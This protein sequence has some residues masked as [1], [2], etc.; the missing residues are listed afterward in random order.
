[1]GTKNKPGKFDCYAAA[2]PDEPMFVLLGRDP[3]APFLV[4]EWAHQRAATR[5]MTEQNIAKVNEARE[6]ARA[7]RAWAAKHDVET[8]DE[9]S[10]GDPIVAAMIGEECAAVREMLLQKNAAYGNSALE[11]LRIFS[12]APTDEQINV[13]IDDKLSRLARGT[14][15]GE[16][17]EADLIGYLV[18]KRVYRR[19]QEASRVEKKDGER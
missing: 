6:C 3:L 5:E 7:M 4:D 13:R 9:M 12:K 19:M 8:P 16:D 17:V 14:A 10:G 18:L 15:A 1:M 2:H 11:P